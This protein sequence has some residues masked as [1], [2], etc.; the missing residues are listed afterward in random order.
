MKKILMAIMAIA[1]FATQV[2]AQE[3]M[4]LKEIYGKNLLS[5]NPF[6][7]YASPELNDVAVGINYEYFLSNFMSV[8]LP[9]N[10]G[11]INNSIQTGLG[12]K[13]YPAGHEGVLKYSIAPTLLYTQGKA[14]REEWIFDPNT[15]DFYSQLV[16]DKTT[17]FGFYLV[18]GLNTTIQQNIYIGMESGLGINYMN[19]V[20]RDNALV[21]KHNPNVGFNFNISLG[22]RF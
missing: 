6:H 13:F 11:M 9:V 2:Q 8:K 12:L 1:T 21:T 20:T 22:Y 14:E 4:K 16:V 5:I 18:S 7:G 19:R 15:Q 10:I 3:R 17:Q